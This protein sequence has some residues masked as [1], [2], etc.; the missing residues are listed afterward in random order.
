MIL[1][2]S[3]YMRSWTLMHIG[4]LVCCYTMERIQKLH[5]HASYGIIAKQIW[6]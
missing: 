6:K 4:F 1:D 5:C 3:E 2:G